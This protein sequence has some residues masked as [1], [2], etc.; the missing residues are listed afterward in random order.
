MSGRVNVRPYNAQVLVGNWFED[1]V[2]EEV[3]ISFS[4][5]ERNQKIFLN[6]FRL[7]KYYKT[8]SANEILVNWLHNDWRKSNECLKQFVVEKYNDKTDRCISLSDRFER[9]GERRFSAIWSSDHADKYLDS[10]SK[11]HWRKITNDLCFGH[12]N[13][14]FA[15]RR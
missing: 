4:C 1:R 8:F 13:S 15:T 3:N 14:V 10:F 2:M 11:M 7:R 5:I 9:S 12:G 6:I